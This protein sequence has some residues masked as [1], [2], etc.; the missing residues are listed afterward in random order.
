VG[1]KGEG[2]GGEKS[3]EERRGDLK[4]GKEGRKLQC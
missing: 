3:A 2:R 4:K 1:I